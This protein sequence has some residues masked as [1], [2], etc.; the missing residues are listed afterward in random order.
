M[1]GIPLLGLLIVIL[2]GG[3]GGSTSCGDACQ[4]LSSC[5]NKFNA[6]SG[7]DLA[8]CN[9]QCQAGTCTNK[10]QLIDCVHGTSCDTT[11]TAYDDA[12]STCEI[13]TM[14]SIGG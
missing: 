7:F 6:G 14:C 8:T 10:Q 11:L 12:I 1:R 5:L 3:C 13:R 9:A 4:S 2:A